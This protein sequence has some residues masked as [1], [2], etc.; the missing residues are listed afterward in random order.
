MEQEKNYYDY[1][2]SKIGERLRSLRKSKGLTQEELANELYIRRASISDFETG[3]ELL[4]TSLLIGYQSY[5][6]VSADYILH[7]KEAIDKEALR[8][9]LHEG[10]ER[11]INDNF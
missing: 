11:F 10:I 4:R 2:L 8:E 6:N 9:Y 3:K 5:F 1:D 7:G